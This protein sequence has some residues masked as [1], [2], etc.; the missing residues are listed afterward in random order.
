MNSDYVLT[1]E[2]IALDMID[3][4]KPIGSILD[5]CRGLNHVFY[6]NIKGCDYCEIQ[7]DVNFFEYT[8]KVDWIIGNPPYSIFKEWMTHSFEVANNIVY[9]LPS[10]KVFNALGLIRLYSK[11][12][13]L[14]HI[15]IYDVGTRIPWSRSRPILAV[16]WQKGYTGDTSWSSYKDNKLINL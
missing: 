10:F 14:K 11:N 4:F 7:E 3:F 6:D 2:F 12:G 15:R 8:N 16:Y 5:P 9:L 1:P 13:W